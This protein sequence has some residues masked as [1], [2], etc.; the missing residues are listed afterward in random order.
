MCNM[1]YHPGSEKAEYIRQAQ[2]LGDFFG[3]RTTEELGDDIEEGLQDCCERV[4][5]LK[6]SI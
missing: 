3:M 5:Y 1:P 6:E 2:D 4:E